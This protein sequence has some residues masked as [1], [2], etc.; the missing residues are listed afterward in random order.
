MIT[1]PYETLRHPVR[2][3]AL[4]FSLEKFYAHPIRCVDKSDAN[5]Q[6]EVHGV[7]RKCDSPFLEIITKT[8]KISL[9]TKAKMI[10]S[11]FHPLFGDRFL[12]GSPAPDDDE[13]VP[14]GKDDLRDTAN[15]LAPNDLAFQFFNITKLLWI[16]DL[17]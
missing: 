2:Y 15:F 10:G 16:P 7:K 3:A 12:V 4:S 6:T 11:P 14:K 13:G 8:V 17:H 5:L 1:S 9:H